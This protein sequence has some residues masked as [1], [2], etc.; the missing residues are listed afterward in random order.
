MKHLCI[1][2]WFAAAGLLVLPAIA[3]PV[4]K[5]EV[6][7]TAP[8]P[9]TVQDLLN[10]LPEQV[11]PEQEVSE[12]EAVDEPM[13]ERETLRPKSRDTAIAHQSEATDRKTPAPKSMARRP[14]PKMA[15]KASKAKANELAKKAAAK[16]EQEIEDQILEEL[17]TPSSEAAEAAA[18]T[19]M[20]AFPTSASPAPAI[21][22]ESAADTP[23]VT[24]AANSSFNS[25]TTAPISR[26]AFKPVK[27]PRSG[28]SLVERLKN[29]NLLKGL[30]AV[31]VLGL[32]VGWMN[33][34]P[35]KGADIARYRELDGLFAELKQLREKDKE[36]KKLIPFKTKLEEASARILKEIERSASSDF[37]ARQQMLWAIKNNIPTILS[38]L[39]I[40][41]DAEK[42]AIANLNQAAILLGLKDA[43][44]VQMVAS[45]NKS[46]D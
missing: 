42:Q 11:P 20:P 38:S 4:P 18:T 10:S 26:P 37:P 34:T 33:M 13:L 35:G 7:V 30:T 14:D 25:L 24:S 23:H 31:V 2:A 36:G 43:P 46:S 29:P 39:A 19:A 5:D 12:E 17:M 40:E 6:L 45:S 44:K 1:A 22:Q 32:F 28:P 3:A 16:L 21:P 9:D 27:P 8:K 15:N 41:S